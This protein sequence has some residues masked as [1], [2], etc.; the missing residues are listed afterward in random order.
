[1]TDLSEAAAVVD[2][3]NA[4]HATSYSVVCLLGGQAQRGWEIRDATGTS[5]VLKFND[6]PI[7]IQQVRRFERVSHHL[8]RH[9]YPAA[10]V[11]LRGSLKKGGYFFIQELLPGERMDAGGEPNLSPENLN[12]LLDLLERHRGIAPEVRQD[13][14]VYIRANLFEGQHEWAELERS[15]GQR[16]ELSSR[17]WSPTW[18]DTAMLSS[19]AK[20]S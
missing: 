4:E 2:E 17:H 14:S 11:L 1:M 20:T 10:R 3:I 6:H 15:H 7:W 19:P 9:G 12:L 16:C 8:R 13:W 5:A 18:H